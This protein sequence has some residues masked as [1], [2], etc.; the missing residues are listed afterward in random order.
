M[1]NNEN[2]HK[3]YFASGCFWGTEY[4]FMKA[5]GVKA[6]TAGFMG[7][8]VD[9]PAYQQVRTGTTGHLECI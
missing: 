8:T 2:M 4:W 1:N 3:S 5:P 6:T 9:N 7:G